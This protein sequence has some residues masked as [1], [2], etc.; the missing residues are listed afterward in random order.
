MTSALARRLLDWTVAGAQPARRVAPRTGDSERERRSDARPGVDSGWSPRCL[1]GRGPQA[2][3]RA[4]PLAGGFF[5][6]RHRHRRLGGRH[7]RRVRRRAKPSL[8]RRH[9][10][11]SRAVGPPQGQRCVSHRLAG[12]RLRRLSLAPRSLARRPR[13]RRHHPLLARYDSPRRAP[14]ELLG[15]RR[16]RRR[17]RPRRALRRGGLGDELPF[18][19]LLHVRPGAHGAPGVDQRATRHAPHRADGRA[20]PASAAIPIVFPPVRVRTLPRARATS[21][22]VHCAWWLLEPGHP[23]RRVAHPR[24]RRALSLGRGSAAA[25]RAAAERVGKPGRRG[26]E[27]AAARADLRRV[28]QRALPRSPR[29]RPRPSACA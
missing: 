15:A 14:A 27:R 1:P 19:A 4:A 29:Q 26:A 24:D 9:A 28:S 20:H 18:R 10:R 25:R 13:R 12:N 7:Q 17:D 23:S 11:P 5:A 16:H 3:R 21:A 6:V 8:R 22:T 2:D